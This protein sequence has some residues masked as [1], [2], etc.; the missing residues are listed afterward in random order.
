ML[1]G[2]DLLV[3]EATGDLDTT[4]NDFN[5]VEN[6]QQ[7]LRQR[8]E[9]RLSTWKGEWGFNTEFGLPVQKIM[10][11][12]GFTEREQIEAEFVQQINLEPDVTSIKAL[13]LDFNPD[14]R[15]FYVK[16]L[17]V[18]SDNEVYSLGLVNP[19]AVVFTYPTPSTDVITSVCG[20]ELSFTGVQIGQ[21]LITG[22]TVWVNSLG[23]VTFDLLDQ[24]STFSAT[25]YPRLAVLYPSLTLPTLATETGSP[26][27]Y[28][29]VADLT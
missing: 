9:L 10:A 8:I 14:T 24:G 22:E 5:F 4:G 6:T 17:E 7:S 20:G 1:Y 28:K 12:S 16:R 13:S 2:L 25:S 15:A 23:V 3:D 29:F 21:A 18:Y 26:F 11:M 19:D 27:P